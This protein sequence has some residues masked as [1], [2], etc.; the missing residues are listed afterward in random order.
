MPLSRALRTAGH[1]HLLIVCL[2]IS[3]APYNS[4][5]G[6]MYNGSGLRQMSAV[7]AYQ[8]KVPILGHDIHMQLRGFAC[9]SQNSHTITLFFIQLLQPGATKISLAKKSKEIFYFNYFPCPSKLQRYIFISSHP[10]TH[11]PHPTPLFIGDQNKAYRDFF[12]F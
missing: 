7:F 11:T 9:I 2:I 3:S 4:S 1:E 8:F 12:N 5:S 6:S 10:P